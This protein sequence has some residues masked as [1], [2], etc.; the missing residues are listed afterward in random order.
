M[1][2]T[3]VW[4]YSDIRNLLV[5]SNRSNRSSLLLDIIMWNCNRSS[6]LLDT[7]MW[8]SVRKGLLM[9]TIGLRRIR[10]LVST[11][12]WSLVGTIVWILMGAKLL[13]SKLGERITK[14]L[15]HGLTKL[16]EALRLY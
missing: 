5:D 9:G 16:F 4:S 12:L 14:L 6:L 1:R 15:V 7:I 11:E 10:S 8:N 13:K 2:N 3:I